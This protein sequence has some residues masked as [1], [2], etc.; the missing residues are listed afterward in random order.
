VDE[1]QLLTTP[2]RANK[3]EKKPGRMESGDRR[4]RLGKWRSRIHGGGNLKF[5]NNKQG[6]GPRVGKQTDLR[7]G[8]AG[9]KPKWAQ[10]SSFNKKTQR[11]QERAEAQPN[12]E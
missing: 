12:K 5:A 6:C 2:W 7:Q 10:A 8:L 4:G 1:F 11:L 3:R 9:K